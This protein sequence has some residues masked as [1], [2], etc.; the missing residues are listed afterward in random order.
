MWLCPA[1]S[2]EHS[3]YNPFCEFCYQDSQNKI[4]NPDKYFIRDIRIYHLTNGAE[5]MTPQEELFAKLFNGEVKIAQAKTLLER[6]ALREEACQIIFHAKVTVQAVDHVNEEEKK[7]KRKVNG[8]GFESEK[9]TTESNAINVIRKRMSRKELIEKQ[10]KE[11]YAAAGNP[12]ADKDAN[13][14]VSARN[15]SGVVNR[16]QNTAK[17]NPFAKKITKEQEAI[18]AILNGG[19]A[20][21]LIKPQ[22]T[23]TEAIPESAKPAYKN[24]FAK[25]V[26]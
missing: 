19:E 10:I 14:A 20:K 24:P 1:C 12:D 15:M 8:P 17:P 16:V 22:V 6:N 18:N 23:V 26:K 2:E 5:P 21:L 4:W 3:D 13:K 9:T 25:K 7:A 11:L